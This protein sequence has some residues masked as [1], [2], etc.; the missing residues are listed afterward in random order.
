MLFCF[1]HPSLLFVRQSFDVFRFLLVFSLGL[2]E[3]LFDIISPNPHQTVPLAVTGAPLSSRSRAGR[4]QSYDD[5]VQ[6]CQDRLKAFQLRDELTAL[7]AWL[8][9]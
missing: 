3:D 9:I 5:L 1:E 6:L 8:V 2:I 4:S 7:Q